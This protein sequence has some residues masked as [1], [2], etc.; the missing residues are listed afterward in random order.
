MSATS[1]TE[2]IARS[3]DDVWAVVRDFSCDAW[4]SVPIT[5]D[6][7]GQ[8]S[9]RTVHGPN[10]DVTERCERLDD[11]EQVLSYSIV[12]GNPFPISGYLATMAVRP[13]DGDHSELVWSATWDT[14]ADPEPIEANLNRFIRGTARVLRRHLDGTD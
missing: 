6:G 3:A 11:A 12:S 2:P 7:E 13:V 9:L 8:G 4:A 5:V 10:G 1:W 14:D